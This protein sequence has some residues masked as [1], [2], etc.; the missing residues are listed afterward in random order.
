MIGDGRFIRY[1]RPFTLRDDESPNNPYMLLSVE[2][3][4]TGYWAQRVVP[5]WELAATTVDIEEWEYVRLID[6][7]RYA[8]S[9]RAPAHR[10]PE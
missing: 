3:T 1:R 4:E 9:D 8:A 10:V 6:E 2:D 5:A 7:L